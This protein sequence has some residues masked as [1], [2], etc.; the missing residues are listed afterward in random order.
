MNDSTVVTASKVYNDF[1]DA[2][3]G[4][5]DS[6]KVGAEHV[7]QILVMQQ[8]VNSVTWLVIF[9]FSVIMIFNFVSAANNKNETWVNEDGDP[10]PLGVFRLVQMIV[11]MGSVVICIFHADVIVTGFINPEYGAIMEIKSFIKK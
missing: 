2:I 3:N 4:I 10:K 5:A 8:I 1:K 11:F 9:C 7:Y 6:L